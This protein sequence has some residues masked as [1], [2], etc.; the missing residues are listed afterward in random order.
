M[1]FNK[2]S[3]HVKAYSL[4]NALEFGKVDPSKIVSK[5]FQHGLEKSDVR[6]IMT[7]IKKEDKRINS[8]KKEQIEKEYLEFSEYVKEKKEE[9]KGLAEL[10]NVVQGKCRS[11]ERRV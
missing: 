4:K 3:V 11:E 1:D 6:Q 8:L 2:L 7:K 10:P 5:L 9:E